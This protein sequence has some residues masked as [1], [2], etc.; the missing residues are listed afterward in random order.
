[1]QS[2][3]VEYFLKT[4]TWLDAIEHTTEQGAGFSAAAEEPTLVAA[5]RDACDGA[6]CSPLESNTCGS[7][8]LLM[9]V[10]SSL[11]VVQACVQAVLGPSSL[12]AV[13]STG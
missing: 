4:V 5:V 9:D 13:G 2:I 1:M 8:R 3:L 10:W 12:S 7:S 11:G 6:L